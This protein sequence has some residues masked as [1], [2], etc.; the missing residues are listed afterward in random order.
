MSDAHVR[1]RPAGLALLVVLALLLAACGGDDDEDATP[2]AETSAAA[3][4]E[5][6]RLEPAAW[7]E[8]VERRDQARTVNE[9]AIAT[10]RRCR[11]LLSTSADEEKVFTCLGDSAENVVTEGKDVLAY[12]EDVEQDV[13]GACATATETLQGNVRIYTATVNQIALSVERS[14]VPSSQEIDTSLAQLA[15]TQKASA[16]FDRAC[17][18]V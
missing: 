3:Q 1:L 10:F 15:A 17:R 13:A 7:D 2:T 11:D 16:A 12:L 6:V 18:P 9:E 5:S 8:Y 14:T 4:A